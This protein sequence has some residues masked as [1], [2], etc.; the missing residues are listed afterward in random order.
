MYKRLQLRIVRH[1]KEKQNGDHIYS[2]IAA[3]LVEK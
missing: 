3:L 2:G 1:N